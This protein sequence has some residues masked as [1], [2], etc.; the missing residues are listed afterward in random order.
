MSENC[1]NVFASIKSINPG[2]KIIFFLSFL[3]INFT[4]ENVIA[5]EFSKLSSF[6]KI[7]INDKEK[8]SS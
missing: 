8:N 6:L 4:I 1:S 5:Y 7:K 3:I 2:K